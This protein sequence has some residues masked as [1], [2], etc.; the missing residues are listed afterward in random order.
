MTI[1]DDDLLLDESFITYE[2]VYSESRIR[3]GSVEVLCVGRE[4]GIIFVL[5]AHFNLAASDASEMFRGEGTPQYRRDGP[6]QALTMGASPYK[7]MKM[8]CERGHGRASE[9]SEKTPWKL[10]EQPSMQMVSALRAG[11]IRRLFL[12]ELRSRERRWTA[13]S[14]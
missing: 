5:A 8:R 11:A 13:R 14:R 9:N 3:P 12:E 7:V 10:E 1:I 4:T 6:E 2:E